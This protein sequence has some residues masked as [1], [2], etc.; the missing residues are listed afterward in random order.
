MYNAALE[1]NE[2]IFEEDNINYMKAIKNNSKN[3][4]NIK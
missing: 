3:I 2:P 1:C 4:Q